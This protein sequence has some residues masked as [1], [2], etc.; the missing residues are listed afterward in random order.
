MDDLLAEPVVTYLAL[1][2]AAAL[3]L[4]E[5][6]L[7]TFGIAGGLSIVLA[8]VGAIG[9][10]QQDNPWW[11]VLLI[12]AVGVAI[13]AVLVARHKAPVGGQVAAAVC[14]AAGSVGFAI[15]SD[16]VTTLVVAVAA[17]IAAPILFPP[18]AK[19]TTKLMNEPP[20][21]GMTS[22]VGRQ[23]EVV[24]WKAGGGTIRLDGSFWRAVD[25]VEPALPPH[26]GET[27]QVVGF[28]GSTL[29]VSRPATAGAP[30]RGV[31]DSPS[32]KG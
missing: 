14:F 29:H 18:L 32:E 24:R 22:L 10:A 17:S 15:S 2:V 19:A 25:L 30:S 16:D 20:T 26:A 31:W 13:W 7:P 1:M 11:P 8:I 28:E 3:F 4:I 27:V 23:G 9:I 21:T 12:S 5:V 6:A